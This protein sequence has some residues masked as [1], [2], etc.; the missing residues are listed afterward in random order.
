VDLVARHRPARVVECGSGTSTVWLGHAV[1]RNGH[2]CVVAL[3]HDADYAERTRRLLD[4]HQ[5]RDRTSVVHAPLTPVE[6]PRGPMPWY[7]VDLESLGMIDLLVVDGPPEATGELARYPALPVLHAHLAPGARILLDDA[8]RPAE[9][10]AVHA[11]QAALPVTVER[12]LAGR[13][14]LLRYDPGADGR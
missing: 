12:E 10:A 8:N 13:A 5:L 1:R 11:W 14:L 3:E 7:S 2:G 6:T 9:S 4:D